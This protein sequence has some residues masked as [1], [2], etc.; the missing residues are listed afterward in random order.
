MQLYVCLRGLL[1]PFRTCWDGNPTD[2]RSD[3][4]IV[5]TNEQLTGGFGLLSTFLRPHSNPATVSEWADREMEP[6]VKDAETQ[7]EF[8]VHSEWSAIIFA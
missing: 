1:E 7:I 4:A 5:T 2:G 8:G 6:G 3:N